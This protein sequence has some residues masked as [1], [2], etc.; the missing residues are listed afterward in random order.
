MIEKIKSVKEIIDSIGTRKEIAK[1]FGIS[2]SAVS[3]WILVNKIAS[4][5]RPKIIELAKE[6]N[7]NLTMLDVTPYRKRKR[8]VE[9]SKKYHEL[10]QDKL[11]N[12]PNQ[13]IMP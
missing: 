5:S 12:E 6:K 13:G 1:L 2:V 10:I 3:H 7:I 4:K 11:N 9:L 8:V